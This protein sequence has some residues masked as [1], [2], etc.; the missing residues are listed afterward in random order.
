MEG[1]GLK[2]GPQ[3][4]KAVSLDGKEQVD[5]LEEPWEEK[6][7]LLAVEAILASVSM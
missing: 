7:E 5:H 3:G 4:G 1:G 6:R 2:G